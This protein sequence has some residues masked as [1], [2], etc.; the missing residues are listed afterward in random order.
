MP[1]VFQGK[2]FFCGNRFRNYPAKFYLHIFLKS[3]RKSSLVTQR[4]MSLVASVMLIV[5]VSIA[6]LGVSVFIYQRLSQN[7]TK[8]ISARCLYLAQAGLHRAI[9]DFR[10]HDLAPNNPPDN[11]GYFTLGQTD[12]DA[13]NAFTLTATEGNLLMVNTATAV[14][15]PAVNP[16]RRTRLQNLTLQNATN[17]QGITITGLTVTWSGVPASRRLLEVN[18][19]TVQLW[20]GSVSSGVPINLNPDFALDM[21]PSI[22]PITF[23][24]FNTDMGNA[25]ITVQFTMLDGSARTVTVYPQSNNNIFTVL[26]TGAT[27]GSNMRKIIRVDYNAFAPGRINAIYATP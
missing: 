17:S 24:R 20:F 19:N 7:E 26:S 16:G 21:A 1:C 6:V 9:Y 2:Y 4:G 27:T 11:N 8:S 5:F 23:L 13:N 22:Y 10:F 12:I 3:L 14:L 15:L 25:I 18:I